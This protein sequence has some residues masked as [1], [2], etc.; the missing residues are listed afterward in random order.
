MLECPILTQ[1]WWCWDAI[2]HGMWFPLRCSVA[3]YMRLPLLDLLLR[4]SLKLNTD[5]YFPSMS[6]FFYMLCRSSSKKKSMPLSC[7]CLCHR[8]I[9]WCFILPW[10]LWI[11]TLHNVSLLWFNQSKNILLKIKMHVLAYSNFR[12]AH[13]VMAEKTHCFFIMENMPV[14]RLVYIEN[15]HLFF[16]LLQ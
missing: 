9:V 5:Y 8:R 12:D 13:F 3:I 11:H 10:F 16:S 2:Q 15:V 6:L 14:F 4:W 7:L 1:P